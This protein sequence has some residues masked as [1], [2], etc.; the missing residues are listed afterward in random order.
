MV[1]KLS[2]GQL[3]AIIGNPFVFHY[4]TKEHQIENIQLTDFI[5]MTEEDQLKTSLCI[6]V[7]KDLP[8][9]HGIIQKAI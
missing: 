4:L 1:K 3:D 5:N 9:L 7:R 8:V 2:A 6:G